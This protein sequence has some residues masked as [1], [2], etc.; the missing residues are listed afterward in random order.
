MSA[1]EEARRRTRIKDVA[2]RLHQ[3]AASYG[4]NG[5]AVLDTIAPDVEAWLSER[6]ASLR[7]EC[8]SLSDT[9]AF[10]RRVHEERCAKLEEANMALRRALAA[11]GVDPRGVTA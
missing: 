1:A 7:T 11:L 10:N 2:D 4:I 6:E 8:S 3:C 5:M 9:I